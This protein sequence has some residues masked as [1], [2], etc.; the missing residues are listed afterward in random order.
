MTKFVFLSAFTI[1]TVL[2]TNA[3]D[4]S[5]S[6]AEIR[7]LEQIVV[8]AILNADT[9]RLKQVWAPEFLVNNPRNDISG[10]RDSVLLTQKAGMINYSS[11][12]RII[13]RIQF[14]KNFIITMGH[15]TFVSRN[16]TPGARAGQTYKRRFTNIW[17]KKNGKWQQTARHASIICQ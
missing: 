12:E 4:N 14:Q 16:D 2:A 7:R 11:F 9:N 8:T 17:I 5:K 10:N 1:T 6:E 13:E 15:E 3:Q